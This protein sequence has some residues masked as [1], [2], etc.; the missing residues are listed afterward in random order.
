VLVTALFFRHRYHVIQV[1]TMPDF[2][3]FAAIIPRLFGANV[4]LDVHDLMPE[5][6]MSKFKV[7]A[8]HPT[9]RR[10]AWVERKSI[11]FA[12]RAIAVHIPHREAL[13][14]HGNPRDKFSILLNV[15]DPRIFQRNGTHRNDDR[16]RLVYHGT[17]ARRHGLEIALRAVHSVRDRIHNLEFVVIG[18]GEDLDRIKALAAELKLE[19]CV[20]FMGTVPVEQ[21]PKHL[22]EV[23]VGI[24]PILYD[25][26]TRYM[27]PLKLM[28]YVGLG[29]PAIVSRT[30]TIEA[31]FDDRM[32]CYV[33]P[34]DAGELAERILELHANPARREALV[35]EGSRFN[36]QYNWGEQK[37]SY[38]ELIDSLIE[39]NRN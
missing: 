30:E 17:V 20:R 27:L 5:L 37:K 23:D 26:F 16:F 7:P 32:V 21:L 39:S 10:I 15:P 31:Y 4:V 9:I 25:D 28:E 3:V 2:M 33:T 19:D 36:A 22:S 12:H 34:G 18:W 1:H 38:F 13:V 29:I 6:Y 35:T 24:V 8:T 14:A 11:A